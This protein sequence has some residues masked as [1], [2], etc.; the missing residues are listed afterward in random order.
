MKRWSA[1]STDDDREGPPLVPWSSLF[2]AGDRICSSSV[3]HESYHSIDKH[4]PRDPRLV[5]II[6]SISIGYGRQG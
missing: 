1:A 6:L 3:D 5:A 4:I 2:S